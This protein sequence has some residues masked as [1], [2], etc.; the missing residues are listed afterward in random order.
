MSARGVL[1]SPFRDQVPDELPRSIHVIDSI[2]FSRLFASAAAVVHHG[3]IGT[4]AQALF[5]GAPQLVM[6]MAFDQHDNADR[7][8]KLGV[9]RSL[10][11]RRF[12]GAAV[13]RVLRELLDSPS[14]A[15]SCRSV[16]DRLG[17]ADARAEA[18]RWIEQAV[19]DGP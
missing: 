14:V 3:G 17:R 7:L 9:A 4:S 5:A 1:V 11:P 8:E 2:P 15:T 19:A 18:C 16:A 12:R 10:L 6:P 13:A